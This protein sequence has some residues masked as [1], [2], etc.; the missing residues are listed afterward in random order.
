MEPHLQKSTK[1]ADLNTVIMY[2]RLQIAY[3]KLWSNVNHT[4]ISL[5]VFCKHNNLKVNYT[6]TFDVHMHGHLEVGSL[7]SP[8]VH[9]C[10]SLLSVNPERQEHVNEPCVLEHSC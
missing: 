6:Y 7:N 4:I 2:I 9:V 5:P 10:P 3:C 1:H 8:A